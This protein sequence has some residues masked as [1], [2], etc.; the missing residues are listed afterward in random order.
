M[1]ISDWSSD[2]CS[3]DLSAM[4]APVFLVS[5]RYRREAQDAI[6]ATGRSVIV[7]QRPEDAARRYAS[8]E[9][10]IA[11]VD[12]RG[13]LPRGIAQVAQ[14]AE[15]VQKRRAG[16]LVLISRPDA[17]ALGQSGRASGR[18]GRG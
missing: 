17:A 18:G 9:A 6:E 7:N 8:S 3:A 15:A 10:L 11:V 2:V 13:A 12:A 1:R 16:L 5:F 14:L 4:T